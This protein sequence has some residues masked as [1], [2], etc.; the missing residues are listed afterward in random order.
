MT[1]ILYHWT[2]KDNVESCRERGIDPS[3]SCGAD[4][5]CWA[6]RT[7]RVEWALR[8]IAARHEW[9]VADMVLLAVAAEQRDLK[10]C[11]KEG[12]FYSHRVM[13]VVGVSAH[14]GMVV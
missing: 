9:A 6:C 7:D 5:R 14:G 4:E 3:Y 10:R 12:V 13:R 8:Y 2:H 11:G 1:T